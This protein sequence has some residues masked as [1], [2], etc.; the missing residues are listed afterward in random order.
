[1]KISWNNIMTKPQQKDTK[2]IKN[3]QAEPT[4]IQKLIPAKNEIE[5]KS[6]ESD[7]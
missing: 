5:N 1:M 4:I 2:Q 7:D 3:P 6:P